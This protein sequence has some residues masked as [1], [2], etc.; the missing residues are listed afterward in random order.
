MDDNNEFFNDIELQYDCWQERSCT[1]SDNWELS[2]DDCTCSLTE[3]NIVI[4]DH[5][6]ATILYLRKQG[7]FDKFISPDEGLFERNM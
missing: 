1:I 6:D 5:N 7:K 2:P 4:H 3:Q